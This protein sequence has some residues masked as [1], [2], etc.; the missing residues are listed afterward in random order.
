MNL[1]ACNN[2]PVKL[3]AVREKRSSWR[4]HVH[5]R[6]HTAVYAH[7]RRAVGAATVAS[8]VHED[9]AFTKLVRNAKKNNK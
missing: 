6:K 7:P 9:L 2:L 5:R 8:A 1:C 4:V 3:L